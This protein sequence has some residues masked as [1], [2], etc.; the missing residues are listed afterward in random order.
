MSQW[1][2]NVT[3]IFRKGEHTLR[4][5][6]LTM[7]GLESVILKQ[8]SSDAF[9]NCG[10]MNEPNA[11]KIANISGTVYV[12]GLKIECQYDVLLQNVKSNTVISNVQGRG[13]SIQGYQFLTEVSI[14]QSTFFITENASSLFA[15][16]VAIINASRVTIQDTAISNK[17]GTG[18]ALHRNRGKIFLRNVTISNNG[19]QG[20][21]LGWT[22]YN[23]TLRNVKSAHNNGTGLVLINNGDN[24]NLNDVTSANNTNGLV[25]VSNGNNIA[26]N[27]IRVDNSKKFGFYMMSNRDNLSLTNVKVNNTK[28][29]AFYIGGNGNKTTLT[30]ITVT[31]T[32]FSE[33]MRIEDNGNEITLVNIVAD[34]NSASGLRLNNNGFQISLDNVICSNTQG[35]GLILDSNEDSIR[36]NNIT[37]TKNMYKSLYLSQNGHNISVNNVV[38]KG[39]TVKGNGIELSY[40][41]NKVAL[42]NVT[43]DNCTGIG[44]MVLA[45]GNSL[46]LSNVTVTNTSYGTGMYLDSNGKNTMLHNITITS[47]RLNGIFVERSD[48]GLTLEKIKVTN[49]GV[50]NLVVS[51]NNNNIAINEVIARGSKTAFFVSGNG[52]NIKV[53][54]VNITNSTGLPLYVS[55]NGNY[56]SLTNVN[57]KT[58]H[59]GLRIEDNGNNIALSNIRVNDFTESS[60]IRLN[61]NGANISLNNIICSNTNNTGLALDNNKDTITLN[62]IIAKNN[63]SGG[64]GIYSNGD[65]IQLHNVTVANNNKGGIEM[66]YNRYLIILSNT[67]VINNTGTGIY[68]EGET[69]VT[70]AHQPT[71]LYNNSSPGNGGGMWIG[72]DIVISSNTVVNFYNNTARGAGGAVY[73]DTR[74]SKHDYK[75]CTFF[76]LRPTF[77]NN[78]GA[79][80]GDD[81]YGGKYAYC[82]G[83]RADT[84]TFFDGIYCIYNLIRFFPTPVSSHISSSPIG[85]CQCLNDSVVDY[86]NRFIHKV[87]YSGQSITIPIVTVGTCGGISPGEI[88]TKNTDGIQVVLSNTNQETEKQCK[89]FTYQFLQQS[90]NIFS[91]NVSLQHKLV[92]DKETKYLM[93]SELTISLTFLPCPLGLELATERYRCDSTVSSINGTEC[94]VEWMPNPIKRYGN[95]WLHYDEDYECIIAHRACPFD[96]CDTSTVYLSLNESHSQCMFNRSGI[97]CGEC[98]QGLS[99]MLGSN[100]C[101][102]C[103]NNYISLFVAFLV[104]GIVLVV[105]LM[106]SNLTVSVGSINGLLFYA[107]IVKLNQTVL[108]PNGISIPVLSQFIAWLNLDLGIQT[109]FFNG[110]DG[111]W[112]TWLQFT[113]PLYIWLLIGFII[114]GSYYSG[115][116]SRL[117]GNNAV[118]VLATLI[119]MSY[120]RLLQ[121]ITNI[122]MSTK[123]KCSTYH[124]IVWNVDGNIGYLSPKHIPL[125]VAALIFLLLGI[126]YTVLVFSGQWLQRYSGKCC[127]SSRDPVVKLKPFIDA[128]TGPYKDN[129]RFWTGLLLIVR[130]VLTPV[131]SY[132]TGSLSIIHNYIIAL[133]AF[134]LMIFMR[135][136][137]RKSTVNVLEYC[138]FLNLAVLCLFS[139][140]GKDLGFSVYSTTIITGVSVSSAMLM[141]I[142]TIIGHIYWKVFGSKRQ[143]H[144]NEGFNFLRDLALEENKDVTDEGSPA[145][146]VMRRE[147]LIFDFNFKEM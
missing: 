116:L 136:I 80:A 12:E 118:P 21:Y 72:R 83:G 9:I 93:Y 126:I 32:V 7:V 129:Y 106:T 85:V 61:N 20:L 34:N 3:L 2:R 49:N 127:K 23:I 142:I 99:L 43:V 119:L 131:F 57:L 41:G 138:H 27:N 139:A 4:D 17:Y 88:V 147:S 11:I 120:S 74:A 97:L 87:L 109:C 140:V 42:T 117:C 112:K 64:I 46:I 65:N 58:C 143:T 45:N 15:N 54:N 25:I 107:N 146:L 24:I 98:Q 82:I 71:T 73:V 37:L 63:T 100:K 103:N 141:F 55:L 6:P 40:N 121:T 53:A 132:T 92:P 35:I 48:T 137:Y 19:K 70:F 101:A 39:T 8:S 56:F 81:I 18:L 135:G 96:Y 68:I 113:F 105:F 29:L 104:A 30:N 78:Y 94:D 33:G 86:N 26:L 128:Y 1:P 125:F 84:T 122:L 91:G 16:A 69:N 66:T 130:L 22:E 36:L 115:K 90:T 133:T 108:F 111:Y 52:N 144:R 10:K 110:L 102:S 38:I 95:N 13:L 51:G 59:H 50:Q 28:S 134:I 76:Y 145:R 5:Q 89:N 114:I 44:L 75:N 124:W 77:K 14:L 47:S 62:N 79:I 60:G 67:S 31:N 123:I